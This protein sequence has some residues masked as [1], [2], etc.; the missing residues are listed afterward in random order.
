MQPGWPGSGR[1][2]KS[3]PAMRNTCRGS[4][5][6]DSQLYGFTVKLMEFIE[7]AKWVPHLHL[8][9]HWCGVGKLHGLLC[10]E[11]GCAAPT[12]DG[13]SA[14]PQTR[15]VSGE[16]TCRGSGGVRRVLESKSSHAPV[17]V[18]TLVY[19]MFLNL[20]TSWWTIVLFFSHFNN[21]EINRLSLS[22][23]G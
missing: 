13:R 18:S 5:Q 15:E 10:A 2:R 16:V 6:C 7:Q 17:S 12:A 4:K 8:V 3:A 20:L 22:L 21:D 23:L 11:G 19:R 14:A 9:F 1:S